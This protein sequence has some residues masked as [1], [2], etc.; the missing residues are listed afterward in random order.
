MGRLFS[1]TS[2]IKG[3]NLKLNHG[4]ALSEN[5]V[6]I[7][8]TFHIHWDFCTLWEENSVIKSIN[9]PKWIKSK[10]MAI[11]RLLLIFYYTL[12]TDELFYLEFQSKF[13]IQL[14]IEIQMVMNL[15]ECM[16]WS[17]ILAV[18]VTS[19]CRST[20]PSIDTLIAFDLRPL[21]HYDVLQRGIMGSI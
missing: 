6:E 18:M 16:F 7:M 17:S 11:H 1:V 13:V 21:F 12:L 20:C 19:V 14:G 5:N 10:N 4:L 9:M 8:W 15:W 2:N 3:I